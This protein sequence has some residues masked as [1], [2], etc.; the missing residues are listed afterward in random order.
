MTAFNDEE[1]FSSVDIVCME[2]GKN[3][4]YLLSRGNISSQQD[5]VFSV[6]HV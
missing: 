1:Q 2:F 3:K 5:G 4:I 6:V